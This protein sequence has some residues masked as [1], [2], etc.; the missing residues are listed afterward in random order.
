MKHRLEIILN[1][2][3]KNHKDLL[4]GINSEVVVNDINWVRSKQCH[5]ITI[6]IYTDNIEESVE[7]H[8]DGINFMMDNGWPILGIKSKPIVMSSLDVKL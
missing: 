7:S 1:K 8:P 6:T 3:L 2:V 4:Y 5:M